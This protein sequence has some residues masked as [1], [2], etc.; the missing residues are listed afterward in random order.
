MLPFGHNKD[1]V[2]Y[3]SQLDRLITILHA[4]DTE[5]DCQRVAL[6]GLSRVRKTQIALECSF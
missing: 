6:V 1:F 2:S 3:Q 5:E 4:E